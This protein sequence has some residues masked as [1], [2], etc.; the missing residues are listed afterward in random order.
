[1]Y[2]QAA[3]RLPDSGV[4]LCLQRRIR[5]ASRYGGV[6]GRRRRRRSAGSSSTCIS[7]F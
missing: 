7:A 6:H 4:F 1:M 3:S 5:G 2:L